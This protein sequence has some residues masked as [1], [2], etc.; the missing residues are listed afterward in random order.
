MTNTSLKELFQKISDYNM[1]R[2]VV[3]VV[4]SVEPVQITIRNEISVQL[5]AQSLIIPSGKK[6]LLE[7]GTELYL[8]SVYS[9]KIFYILDRT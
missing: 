5:S 6:E 7:V 1:P 3:G 2:I 9:N 8:L 4:T